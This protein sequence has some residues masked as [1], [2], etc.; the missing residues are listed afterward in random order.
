MASLLVLS[1]ALLALVGLLT[2][3]LRAQQ[4]SSLREGA[5]QVGAAALERAESR[6]DADWDAP[7]G[8]QG[9]DPADPRFTVSLTVQEENPLLKR[10]N[11]SVRWSDR[12][13]DQEERF[14]TAVTRA[15]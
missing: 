13:G 15:P 7:V 4:K 5:A 9:P 8:Y 10:L 3:S 12:E 14:Q 1:I 6:L 2:V 11:V